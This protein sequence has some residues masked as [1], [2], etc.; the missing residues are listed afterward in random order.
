MSQDDCLATYP[1]LNT[2]KPVAE[3]IWIVDGP[4]IRF[5]IP[6]LKFPFPT[7]MTVVRCA[8]G[9]LFIHSPTPLTPALRAEIDREGRVRDIIGPNRIH[10]WWIPD[11]QAAFPDAAIYLAPGIR[12]QAKDRIEFEGRP[13]DRSG[14]YPWDDEIATLPVV[15]SYMTEVEFFHRPSR[16]LILTDL[17]ENFEPAKIGAG[18]ARYL[19]WIGGVGPPHGGL[20]RELRLTF[21]WRHRRELRA[22]VET[23]L[24]WHPERIVIAHGAWH[25]TD[26]T[27][28]L[29]EAFCWL[30]RP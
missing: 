19:S 10:Y 30:L 5:G 22:A 15:G 24:G 20:P 25:R 9:D 16:T 12:A 7:R 2:L 29:R 26:G 3:N 21:T 1:P 27:E 17:M 11:W 8:S 14:G 13:L 6:G 18:L 4:V 23:M 28:I